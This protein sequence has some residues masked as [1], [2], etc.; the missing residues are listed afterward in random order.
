MRF[1]LRPF[2]ALFRGVLSL[3]RKLRNLVVV[4]TAATAL[5]FVLDR[6]LFSEP[7]GD[8]LDDLET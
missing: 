1:V 2:L 7:E 3:L 4:M 6:L 8:E 5:L